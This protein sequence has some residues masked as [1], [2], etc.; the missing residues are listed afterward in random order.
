M[1]IDL[2]EW[3][4]HSGFR[5]RV[6]GATVYIDPYRV[7][8]GPKGDVILV[9][10]AHYDHYSPQDI[11]KLTGEDTVLIAPSVVAERASGNVISIAPGESV[12]PGNVRGIEVTAVAAYNTS[13]RAPDGRVFHPPEAGCVGYD[14]NVRGERLY[15]AGDT[16]VIP[17]MDAVTGVDV[18]LLPVSGTYVMTAGEAVEAARRIQPG[19]AV[20]MHWGEHIGTLEDA[21]A[22]AAK[23]PV[24]VRILRKVA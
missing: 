22:F 4:G 13:K 14:L 18:A 3:L 1:L 10:H 20:P 17:E 11:E 9:T 16:D 23:A 21:E 15:H 6:P 5:L 8:D 7:T 19:V 12:M 2:L 24:E